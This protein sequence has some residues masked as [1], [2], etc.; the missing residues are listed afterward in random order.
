M[1]RTVSL[2]LCA[3]EY[4]SSL[5][6]NSQRREKKSKP[7]PGDASISK[8]T[9]MELEKAEDQVLKSSC[10]MQWLRV[11][12]CVQRVPELDSS[13]RDRGKCARC[14]AMQQQLL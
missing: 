10:F 4:T 7:D 5:R 8:N 11:G 9:E 3:K 2:C 12:M 13:G 1:Q 14:F 6:L